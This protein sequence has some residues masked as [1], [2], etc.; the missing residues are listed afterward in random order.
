MN[1][2]Q[3]TYRFE[4]EDSPPKSFTLNFDPKSMEYLPE[5]QGIHPDWTQLEYHQC[6]HC[7]LT[8]AQTKHC[9]V[10]RNMAIVSSHFGQD[11]SFR[12]CDVIVET[13]E[14]NYS[15][16]TSLQDGLFGILGL[17]MSTSGCPHMG[18]LKPMARFHLPFSSLN[19]TLVRTLS[20]HL[21][22]Q[23]FAHKKGAAPDRNFELLDEQY[24]QVNR[25]NEG[26]AAR[27]RGAKGDAGK[28]ALVILDGFASM[29]SMERSTDFAEIESLLNFDEAKQT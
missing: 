22:I 9:P 3:I 2:L 25:V 8:A 6:T 4:F 27:I 13:R 29:L 18:F 17:I 5:E 23:Y 26:I 1:P 7:P 16:K 24:K 20:L 11:K 12:E 28:N 14:R 19:E 21:L 10:A 15:K